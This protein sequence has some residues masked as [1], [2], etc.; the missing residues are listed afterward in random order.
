MKIRRLYPALNLVLLASLVAGIAG[1]SLCRNAYYKRLSVI[2]AVNQLEYIETLPSIISRGD[3]VEAPMFQDDPVYK[4]NRNLKGIITGDLYEDNV[5]IRNVT[6][7]VY[8][9]K[10]LVRL[11]ELMDARVRQ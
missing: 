9:G 7:S 1:Y 10:S 4:Y 5:S 6:V 2:S 11:S 3:R 8:N